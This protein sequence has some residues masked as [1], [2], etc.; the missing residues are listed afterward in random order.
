MYNDFGILLTWHSVL[1][2]KLSRRKAGHL[3]SADF[4]QM[5]TVIGTH[6]VLT[7][8]HTTQD[9]LSSRPDKHFY[10]FCR[11]TDRGYHFYFVNRILDTFPFETSQV[12]PIITIYPEEAD[13]RA[14]I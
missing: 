14:K 4:P 8:P 6:S 13:C 2:G 9:K 5:N 7:A 10:Y 11:A 12:I 1:A 3:T